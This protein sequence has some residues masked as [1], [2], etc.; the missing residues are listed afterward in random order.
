MMFQLF[1]ALA[2]RVREQ[3]AEYANAQARIGRRALTHALDPLGLTSA[4]TDLPPVLAPAAGTDLQPPR[5]RSE[6]RPRRSSR[7]AA[8]RGQRQGRRPTSNFA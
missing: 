5:L 8:K 2:D 6:R 1:E 3:A 7:P 4:M